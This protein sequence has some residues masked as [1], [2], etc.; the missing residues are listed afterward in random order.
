MAARGKSR[1]S[2]KRLGF[3]QCYCPGQ[4]HALHRSQSSEMVA[5]CGWAGT[6]A[7]PPVSLEDSD[8]VPRAWGLMAPTGGRRPGAGQGGACGGTSC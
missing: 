1:S 8:L 7:S 5:D 4:T 3:S 2:L 6:E